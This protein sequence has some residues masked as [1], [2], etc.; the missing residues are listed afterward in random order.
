MLMLYLYVLQNQWL[1]ITLLCGLALVLVMALT[2]QALWV[3][4]GTEKRS[5]T[6]KVRGPLSFLAWVRIFTPWVIILLFL[7]CIWFTVFEIVQNHSIPPN[8]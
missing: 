5:E 4:R 6:V 8:W 1:V 3:P 7:A 2:Y